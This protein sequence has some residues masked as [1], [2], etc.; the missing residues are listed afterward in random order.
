VAP[1]GA[2]W[3]KPPDD[4]LETGAGAARGPID[5]TRVVG[6]L[7]AN[8]GKPGGVLVG[9]CAPGTGSGWGS[10]A[11]GSRTLTSNGFAQLQSDGPD[12]GD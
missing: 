10:Q 9:R 3:R 2:G 5:F 1:I 8:Q 6:W 4:G 7:G 11:L 12:A